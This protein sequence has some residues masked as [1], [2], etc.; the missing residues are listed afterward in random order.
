MR[1]THAQSCGS[2]SARGPQIGRVSGE[3]PCSWPLARG[4]GGGEPGGGGGGE[5]GGGVGLSVS[6]CGYFGVVAWC[7]RI[8]LQGQQ[9][10]EGSRQWGTRDCE[11]TAWPGGLGPINPVRGVLRSPAGQSRTVTPTPVCSQ[12]RV[13]GGGDPGGAIWGGGGGGGHRLPLPP[14]ALP[15]TIPS[16]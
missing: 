1:G 8:G 11:A 7:W 13:G 4:R 12:R 14:L 2:V 10:S 9:A 6:T 3:P 15:L 16:P 5:R